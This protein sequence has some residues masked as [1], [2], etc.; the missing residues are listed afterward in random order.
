MVKVC[1][2]SGAVEY[3]SPAPDLL[4]TICAVIDERPVHDAILTFL[5]ATAGAHRAKLHQKASYGYV[6]VY[7][8]GENE[9]RKK[10]GCI[11]TRTLIR[12]IHTLFS[13][14]M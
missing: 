7:S 12:F 14:R 9:A 11:R 13:L 2:V 8:A 6:L 1:I 3:I 10:V 4:L 5:S